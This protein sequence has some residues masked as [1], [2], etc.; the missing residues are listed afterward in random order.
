MLLRSYKASR[1]E[2]FR[3]VQLP[4]SLPFVFAGLDIGI[5]LS[6]IGTIVGEFVG[7]TA[8]IGYILLN[9]NQSFDI[10]GVFACL[11]VLSLIG[12]GLH[13]LLRIIQRRIVFWHQPGTTIGA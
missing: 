11:I 13:M 4:A 9:F 8:G 2:I 3:I 12:V 10:A 5:V 7:T 1:M 6:V